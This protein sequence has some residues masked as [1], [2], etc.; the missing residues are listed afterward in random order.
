MTSVTD[1]RRLVIGGVDTHKDVHVA[2]AI[3]EVGRVLGTA[4]FPTT[5]SGHRR[6]VAWLRHHGEIAKVGVEG[7]GSYGA[8]LARFLAAGD[9]EVVE[10]D[11]PNRQLR[12][13]RG[14]SDPVDAE[15][16][17]RAALSGD[18]TG[19]PK[20]R[21]GRVEMIRALRIARR[22]AIKARTQAANQLHALVGAAPDELRVKLRTLRL[23]ALVARA[24]RFRP[25]DIDTPIAATKLALASLAR[26]FLELSA[27]VARLD[28]HLGRLVEQTAPRLVARFGV[29]TDTAGA[30]L[31]AAGDNP[32][33]LRN[34]RSFAA[35]CGASPVDA[36]SGH[37]RRHRLNRGGDRQANEALWRIVMV[38]LAWDP[39]TRHYFEQRRKDGKTKKE[40]IRCLKRYVAREIYAELHALTLTGPKP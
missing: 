14:K 21:C 19:E 3:S 39:T 27:E 18:A 16:A 38:R 8:G 33:R 25:G 1:E 37:Q 6:L 9:V 28:A 24:A 7:T 12:R 22:S 4:E 34:E 15:A 40:T 32:E 13:R 10:V 23:D 5:T 20:S 29:G 36:S 17:A 30:L 11:R 35:L 26:R 2:A 31:V